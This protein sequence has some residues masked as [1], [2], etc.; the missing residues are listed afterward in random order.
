MK[1]HLFGLGTLMGLVLWTGVLGLGCAS[2][3]EDGTHD[4]AIAEDASEGDSGTTDG[5]A[6]ATAD[7]GGAPGVPTLTKVSIVSHGVIALGWT[8]PDST[9]SFAEVMRKKDS[10]AYALAQKLAGTAASVQ[11]ILSH[12]NTAGVYCYTVAC[13]LGGSLSNASNEKCVTHP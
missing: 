2:G 1:I 3:T 7:A 8:I 9:C 5:S 6:E 11:D 13:S 12:T 4:A 10:G